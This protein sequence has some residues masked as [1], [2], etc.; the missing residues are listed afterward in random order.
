[1]VLLQCDSS[2]KLYPLRIDRGDATP[3]P[4]QALLTLANGPLWHSRLGHPG[5][6]A[7]LLVSHRRLQL[8]QVQ[9]PHVPYQ[10]P[11]KHMLLPFKESTNVSSLPFQ[12]LHC[13]VWT[14]QI[15][16]NSGYKFYL[17]IL[18]DFS[19][20]VWT[21]SL[22]HKSDVLPT[23]ISFHAFVGTQFQHSIQCF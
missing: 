4:S 13:D 1:M 6:D 11:C 3:R 10:S 14:S 17:V 18:D 8:L 2:G 12:L 23:L 9:S 19:H 7:L 5:H 22:R 21:F 20:Y 15:M 16:S